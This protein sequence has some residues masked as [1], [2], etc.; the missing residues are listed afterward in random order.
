MKIY[1]IIKFF[2]FIL[3]GILV[4]IFHDFFI[5]E[6]FSALPLLIGGV[7]AFYG[8]EETALIIIR[9]EVK[10]ER[11]EI[12]SSL[13]TLLLGIVLVFIVRGSESEIVA[14]SILWSVWAIMRES[15]EINEKVLNHLDCKITSSI[16]FIES[17]VVIVYSIMLIANPTHHHLNSHLILLGVEL[18]LEVIW[19]QFIAI[20]KNHIEKR[21]AIKDIK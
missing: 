20:E 16:N 13:I 6:K 21:K 15:E 4:L 3:A 14:I 1:K 19:P 9:K 8:I 5:E 10:E 18:I 11:G 12:I 17:V 7:M 2:V